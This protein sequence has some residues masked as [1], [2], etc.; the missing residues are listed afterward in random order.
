MTAGTMTGINNGNTSTGAFQP[1]FEILTSL[2]SNVRSPLS[3]EMQS[4]LRILRSEIHDCACRVVSSS[5][6]VIQS[7]SSVPKSNDHRDIDWDSFLASATFHGV[8]PILATHLKKCD[9]L[10]MPNEFKS[11]VQEQHARLIKRNMFLTGELFRLKTQLDRENIKFVCM[12]GPTLAQSAY[13]DVGMRSF[14]DL[15]IFVCRHSAWAAHNALIQSGF[16]QV[17]GN[18]RPTSPLYIRLLH[19]QEFRSKS[20]AVDLHW[21]PQPCFIVKFTDEQI[22]RNTVAQTLL[23]RA[24]NVFSPEMQFLIL[25][26]NG[27]KGYWSKLVYLVDLAM[28][29]RNC[30]LDERKLQ[31]LLEE[32]NSI[33]LVAF[34]MAMLKSVISYDAGHARGLKI[35]FVSQ[36]ANS[37]FDA[38]TLQ[39]VSARTRPSQLARELAALHDD[40]LFHLNELNDPEISGRAKHLKLRYQLAL[41]SSFLERTQLACRGVFVPT[42][43]DWRAVPLPA[44]MFVCYYLIRPVR[45]I[46]E[47]FGR[48]ASTS[49]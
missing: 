47:M 33:K 5:T 36:L 19:E 38:S 9:C 40:A 4:L 30:S 12:K 23:G 42:I 20:A 28:L 46:S 24:V 14:G 18:G 29:L 25:C 32:T 39:N 6:E 10:G 44:S 7:G 22:E 8:L 48:S 15:D 16:E 27:V 1:D 17:Q 2:A 49:S 41:R 43:S 45:L 11:K 3:P 21:E 35:P 31:V 26:A 13:G 34:A 37:I